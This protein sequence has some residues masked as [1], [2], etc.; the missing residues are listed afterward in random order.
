MPWGRHATHS[1]RTAVRRM[2]TREAVKVQGR[3]AITYSFTS[4]SGPGP[5]PATLPARALRPLV[6]PLLYVG[7]PLS[8][9]ACCCCRS[10]AVVLRVRC[11]RVGMGGVG[12]E[13]DVIETKMRGRGRANHAIQRCAQ[14][15][16]P[17]RRPGLLWGGEHLC[18]GVGM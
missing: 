13:C 5:A 14:T 3:V 15:Y 11:R 17:E 16:R 12:W 9:C 6:L 4:N 8:C 10:A 2:G 7:L 1:R 18:V